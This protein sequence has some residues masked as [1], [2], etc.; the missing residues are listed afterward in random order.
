MSFPR[1]LHAVPCQFGDGSGIPGS[2]DVQGRL[3]GCRA[4]DFLL[5]L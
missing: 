1:G 3:S 4:P 2:I 5:G